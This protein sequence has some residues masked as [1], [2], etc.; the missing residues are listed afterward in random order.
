MIHSSGAPKRG[1]N[2]QQEK[3]CIKNCSIDT[4]V[5]GIYVINIVDI[6]LENNCTFWETLEHHTLRFYVII[7]R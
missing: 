5:L 2:V 3:F 1:E 4:K 7:R 6:I